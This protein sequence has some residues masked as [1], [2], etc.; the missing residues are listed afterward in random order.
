[1]RGGFLS[2]LKP[3]GMTSHDVVAYLRRLLKI[4]KIGHSGTLDPAA[5]GILLVALDQATRLLEF[6][7]SDKGY[8]AEVTLG[9]AT[10]TLDVEGEVLQ[11]APLLSPPSE[12][13]VRH[14]LSSF[15]G[16]QL[17]RPPAFSAIKVQG[18]KLYELAR[19]G[20]VTE[21]PERKVHIYS[22]ELLSY[23]SGPFPKILFSVRCSEGTYIR[24]LAEDLGKALGVPAYLSFLLRDQVGPLNIN[25]STTLE[26]L[27]AAIQNEAMANLWIPEEG[28]LG[29]IKR[30]DLSA[31]EAVAIS[32]G[33]AVPSA[34][35]EGEIFR[36][37]T[38]DGKLLA[39]GRS[40]NR[41]IQPEKVFADQSN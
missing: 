1:M 39:M 38:S 16:E 3:P 18:K 30:V 24:T 37:Y 11:K 21:A 19:K 10:T 34:L 2:I 36:L 25:G 35:E 5:S 15:T 13:Q 41:W 12:D 9:I 29:H 7:P 17:Q 27:S 8:I 26:E 31:D 32:K 6:L 22:L 14:A 20:V 40:K 23:I 33:K 28:L 4:K